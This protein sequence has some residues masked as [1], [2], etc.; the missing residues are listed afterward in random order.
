[1]RQVLTPSTRYLTKMRVV[2]VLVAAI[3]WVSATVLGLAISL[4]ERNPGILI[5][6][7]VITFVL[8]VL[9][10]VP[11]LFLVGPYYRSL[12]YEI[13]QEEVI[14]HAGIWT[15]SVKHVPY[16]TVT[17]LTVK[18]GLLDRWIFQLGTL[19]IQT[20]GTSGTTEA[21]QS[22]V[23]LVDVDEVYEMVATELRRFRG[24]MP[25]TATGAES[26]VQGPAVSSEVPAETLDAILT[27]VRA[28]RQSLQ[29][30]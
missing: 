28:I 1:M 18:R 13:H 3:I 29:K 5:W 14:V 15:Q 8:D 16:R 25:P 24:S 2:V 22:L 4:G 23:G 19:D 12:R 20:A 21:E 6:F 27:E 26:D 11:A 7:T 9:W 10:A 17:N 30:E